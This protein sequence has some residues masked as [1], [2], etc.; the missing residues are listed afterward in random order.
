MGASDLKTLPYCVILL[1]L[2]RDSSMG[3]TV[4]WYDSEQRILKFEV[5]GSWT[6][7]DLYP[8]I[9]R[10]HEL[11]ASVAH[12]KLVHTIFDML[13]AA[14]NI[15][16]N[17]ISHL[18]KIAENQAP[19]AGVTVLVTQSRLVHYFYNLIMGPYQSVLFRSVNKL[20]YHFRISESVEQADFIIQERI[21]YKI[22]T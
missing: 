8:Q 10:S 14:P 13:Q 5:V 19:N 18:Q 7:D 9:D 15:P 16:P 2:A 4:D 6:W 17:A 22:N 1:F 12:D 21:L 20:N 3:I 11:A